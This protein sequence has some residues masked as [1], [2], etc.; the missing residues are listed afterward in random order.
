MPHGPAPSDRSRRADAPVGAGVRLR[1]RAGPHD[2]RAYPDYF[3]IYTEG[4]RWKHSGELWTDWCGGFHA[5]MMWLIA[6]RTGDA[7]WRSM[8]EH[9]SRLLEH[10]QHDRDVHDLGFIFLNTYLP[11]YRLTGDERL[12]QVLITAGRTLALR[13][14][15]R[16]R[17]LRSFVAPESL[18]IDIMMNVPLDL[19]RRARGRRPRPVRAGSRALPH[20][21]ADAGASRRLD[22]ARGD[23]RPGDRRVLR[24]VDPTGPACRL[25]LDSRAGLVALRLQHGLHLHRGP[26][27]SRRRPPQCRRFLERCPEGLVPPWDFDVPGRARPDRRQFRRR[28]R[29]VGPV[30]PRRADRSGRSG[31][32]R[33]YR[34]ASLTILDTLC[35]DRYLAWSTPGWEGVLK[36]GVYHIHK[37]LGVDES[38]MW[39]DFFFLEAVDKVLSY[40]RPKE[41]SG[42]SNAARV[43][44]RM[45]FRSRIRVPNG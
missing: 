26:G 13:F 22:G 19:L 35:S 38:V 11:W 39:G 12:H 36:H 24:A 15:P 43:P 9:Y 10:R 29:R 21:R 6:R 16:G 33:R 27:R 2:D 8:A 7:W 3:P 25:H 45:A 30:G 4:G 18:F 42:E 5:G 28:D 31:A 44:C 14:N 34:D 41:P 17:Y 37:K 32:G 20:H 40:S 1:R 23:L